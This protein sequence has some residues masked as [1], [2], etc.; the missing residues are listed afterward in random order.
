MKTSYS[1]PLLAARPR[2]RPFV[3]VGCM[4]PFEGEEAVREWEEAIRILDGLYVFYTE[5]HDN[6]ALQQLFSEDIQ[7]AEAMLKR[8]KERVGSG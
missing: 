4:H 7:Q 3:E 5:V 8:M 6:P 1:T 2:A